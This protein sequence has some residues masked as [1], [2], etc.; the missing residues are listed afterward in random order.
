M[1]LGRIL[2]FTGSVALILVGSYARANDQ[3]LK[4]DASETIQIKERVHLNATMQAINGAP[5]VTPWGWNPVML[6]RAVNHL[7]SLG[8]QKAIAELREFLKI[9]RDSFRANRDP[10]DIDTSDEQCVF[11]IVRLLFELEVTSGTLPDLYIGAMWLR[12]EKTDS[13]FWPLY[14]LAL[15]DDVPFLLIDGVLLSGYP[16]HPSSHVDWAEKHGKLRA[17][18]LRP[19]DDPIAAVDKLIA[20]PQTGRLCGSDSF[21]IMLRYEAWQAIAHLVRVRI[22]GMNLLRV[23]EYTPKERASSTRSDSA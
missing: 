14:P 21:K 23:V 18:P 15:Q 2:S 8:K 6:V 10:A 4:A 12:P 13:S 20:Q 16:Q 1:A 22:K 19:A 17:Q 5:S 11:L 3:P 7:Q 9:A